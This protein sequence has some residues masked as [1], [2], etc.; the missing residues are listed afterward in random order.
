MRPATKDIMDFKSISR[1]IVEVQ[2]VV[3]NISDGQPVRTVALQ[4]AETAAGAAYV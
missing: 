4:S 1:E 2:S 3:K